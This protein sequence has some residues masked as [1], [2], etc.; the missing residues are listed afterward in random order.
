MDSLTD[1]ELSLLLEGIFRRYGFDFRNYAH[2]SLK[3][4]IQQCMKAEQV[5]TIS[6]LQEKVLH[7]ATCFERLLLNLS[8]HV[9][10]MFRDPRFYRIFRQEIVPYLQTYP[11]IRIWHAGCS[12]GEEVYSMAI[13]L[14]EERLYDRA[15]IYAT[16]FNTAVLSRAETGIFP[17][18]VM[19]EYTGNYILAEGKQAFSDYYTARYDHVIFRPALQRNIVWAQHNLVTD[20]SFNEFHVIVCRNTMIYFNKT[21]QDRVHHLFHDSLIA[22]GFLGL[23]S[24]ESIRFTPHVQAYSLMDEQE[25]W[26]RKAPR[27]SAP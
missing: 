25:K 8:I 12:T 4:R 16:D 14:E 26:Y 7:D 10:S 13:L 5:G 11:F 17:L 3:R 1:L 15:R 19:Q 27:G 22:S 24:K 9:T 18:R 20:G 21:L 2:A 6:A 23:G